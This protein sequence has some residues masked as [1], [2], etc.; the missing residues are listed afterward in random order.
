MASMVIVVN[1]VLGG[2]SVALVGDLAIKA[3]LPVAT[4]GGVAAGIGILLLSLLYEHRLLTPVVLGSPA[5][6][7]AARGDNTELT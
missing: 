1:S 2:A 7:A 3:P 5:A 6:S 4:G